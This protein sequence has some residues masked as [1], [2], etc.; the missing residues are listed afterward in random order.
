MKTGFRLFTIIL[1]FLPLSCK[2]EEPPCT[3]CPPPPPTNCQYPAGN[4]SFTWR[5]DTVAWFPST[6][7]GVWAF[8]DS[9]AYLM[10]NIIQY[11]SGH[12]AGYV[13]LHWNGSR[14][15]TNINGSVQEIQHVAS[16]VAGDDHHMVSVGNWS[17]TP[18]KPALGEF[19]N[20]TKRWQ[21]YQFQTQGELRSVWTDGK[22]YFIAVGD[23]GMVYT[24]DGYTA[25]WVYSQA[26]TDFNFYKVSAVSKDEV[27]VL[28]YKNPASGQSYTQVLKYDGQSWIKMYDTEDSTGQ[29]LP[30]GGEQITD[31]VP[32]RCSITDSLKL[33]TTGSNSYLFESKGGGLQFLKIN[34]AEWGLPLQSN[35]RTGLDINGYSPDD[36]WIFGTRY[37]F[38]HWNGSDFQRM[39]IPGL[40]NNDTQF[41]DQRRMAKTSTGRLFLPTEVSSQVYV[42][43][44]GIP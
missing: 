43:V 19:D 21:G 33:F 35:G 6:L 24:K 9:D 41:G 17:I 13:G 23:N 36:L 32:M 44:Q 15:D 25:G 34:L 11:P 4:R 42:V 16:D 20:R 3:T 12:F 26:P 39:I 28:G 7:G 38:Y 18:P 37:N 31:V 40:P 22:G 29:A 8:S 1:L 2:K 5:S 27:Y 10:G 30:L 14:W